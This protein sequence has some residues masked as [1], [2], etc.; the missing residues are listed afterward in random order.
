MVNRSAATPLRA[1]ADAQGRELVDLLDRARQV[2]GSPRPTGARGR[3]RTADGS[4]RSDISRLWNQCTTRR[5]GRLLRRKTAISGSLLTTATRGFSASSSSSTSC[6]YDHWSGRAH[7]LSRRRARSARAQPRGRGSR[8]G[9]GQVQRRA[10]GTVRRHAGRLTT[11][12]SK[13][14]AIADP[15]DLE[16]ARGDRAADGRRERLA[17][18]VHEGHRVRVRR[19]GSRLPHPGPSGRPAAGRQPEPVVERLER[20]AEG[21]EQRMPRPPPPGTQSLGAPSTCRHAPTSPPSDACSPRCAPTSSAGSRPRAGSPDGRWRRA[22]AAG[23]CCAARSPPGTGRRP[24]GGR[25]VGRVPATTAT[26]PG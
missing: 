24:P 15:S 7:P 10:T 1:T 2:A 14:S 17:T 13:P 26:G 3:R 16:D 21:G 9:A 19:R 5:S 20:R 11:G 8:I 4:D 23:R 18:V 12:Q 25:A 22:D 6:A